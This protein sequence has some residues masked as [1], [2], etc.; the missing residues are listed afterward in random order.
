MPSKQPLKLSHLFLAV[1][2]IAALVIGTHAAAQT[3]TVLYNFN[4]DVNPLGQF[5]FDTAGNLYG[6]ANGGE[7]FELMPQSDG[8]WTEKTIYDLASQGFSYSA[9]GVIFD[10]A[11]N[12]YGSSLYSGSY[13]E[14]TAFELKPQ[15]DGSWREK[16][17]HLSLIHI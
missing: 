6:T 13:L 3:E 8:S 7:V 2:A 15:S 11:G 10:R 17:L 1:S 12:L 9:G 14:G 4:A 16:T 5:V